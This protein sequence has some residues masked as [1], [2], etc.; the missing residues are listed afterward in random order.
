MNFENVKFELMFKLKCGI[1]TVENLLGA[2][3]EICPYEELE[4]K[5]GLDMF[6][7]IVFYQEELKKALSEK[8][9]ND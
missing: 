3:L 2:I 4:G 9:K 7:I 6:A 8:L 1:D 5:T